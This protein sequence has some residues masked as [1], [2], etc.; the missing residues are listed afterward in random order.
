MKPLRTG[1]AVGR[2]LG[3]Q[4]VDLLRWT[5][6]TVLILP[7]AC[8]LGMTF[9]LLSAGLLASGIGVMAAVGLPGTIEL[10]RAT[11]RALVASLG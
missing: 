8:L 4:A 11:N 7:Q 5:L 1:R 9:P 3:P 2:N 10:A 6:A